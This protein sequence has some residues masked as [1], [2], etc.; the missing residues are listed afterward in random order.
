MKKIKPYLILL[1][2]LTISISCGGSN[3]NNDSGNSSS[4]T[5][6]TF[7]LSSGTYST[8]MSVSITNATNGSTIYYTTDG[9]IPTT[10]S[11]I[12]NSPI[13]VAGNGA[14]ITIQAIAA[15]AGMSNSN[16]AVAVYVIN[17]KQVSTPNFSPTAGMCTSITISCTTPAVTIYYTTDGNT[18]TT[19]SAIYNAPIS[20]TGSGTTLTVSALAVKSGMMD[21]TVASTVYNIPFTGT[22]LWST[23][24]RSAS[25]SSRFTAVAA[26]NNGNSYAIGYIINTGLFDFGG[27][28][29]PINGI[30]SNS[31]S[32]IVKYNSSG[33]A[34]WAKILE[35]GNCMF[36]GIATDNSGNVFVVGEFNGTCNFGGNSSIINGIS[37]YWNAVIIKYNSSGIAQWA[38]PIMSAT[39]SSWFYNVAVDQSGNAYAV[40]N[41]DG[42]SSFN[43]GGN[44]TMFNGINVG[45]NAVIVKYNSSGE[46][47][48]ATSLLSASGFTFFNGVSVDQSG[49]AYAV[50]S[51]Q[52]ACSFDYGGYSTPFT[53]NDYGSSVIVK[54]STS[55]VTQWATPIVSAT[56]GNSFTSVAVDNSNNAYAV[57]FIVGT[58]SFNYGCGSF[59]GANG[60]INGMYPSCSSVIVKYNSSGIPQWSKSSTAVTT[61]RFESV[62][63]DRWGNAYAAGYIYDNCDFGGSSI[64]IYSQNKDNSVIVKYSTT[65]ITDW[66]KSTTLSSDFNRFEGITVDHSGYVYATGYAI[67]T[68]FFSFGGNSNIFSGAYTSNNSIIVKYY[69]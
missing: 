53:N 7:N 2:F 29:S 12:Y 36:K 15:M 32:V 1:L 59:N 68:G 60:L 31:N 22:T 46:A 34:Q 54:Y 23:P 6:P 3:K 58:G 5:A 55:G 8:D 47:Q 28:S 52:N 4:V 18:P 56:G 66:A 69:P 38:T 57:G 20:F 26:D 40:G 27:S 25:D 17:Y 21:S 50:G 63:V 65:G 30:M 48:W 24:I 11:Q 43:F 45:N 49:N 67:G 35:S 14:T 44:S 39:N 13:V 62:S 16:L 33:V 37:N 64:L 9:S 51:F 41:V 10:L 61:S 19:S 42:S